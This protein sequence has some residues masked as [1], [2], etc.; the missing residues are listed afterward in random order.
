MHIRRIFILRAEK[1]PEGLEVF[2]L[3]IMYD[4]T[5]YLEVTTPLRAEKAGSCFSHC[6]QKSFFSVSP[7]TNYTFKI[8][9]PQKQLIHDNLSW[10][11]LP[12]LNRSSSGEFKW[13]FIE[14]NQPVTALFY[15]IEQYENTKVACISYEFNNY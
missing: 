4:G 9:S 11:T 7:R 14:I 6:E 13:L 2:L 1:S 8:N 10:S 12:Y 5:F 15:F 3:L